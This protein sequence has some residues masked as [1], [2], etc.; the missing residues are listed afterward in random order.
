MMNAHAIPEIHILEE[1]EAE[2]EALYR[3]LIHNDNVTPM[4]FVVH[5]LTTIFFLGTPNAMDIM[6]K[7]HITGTAYVQTVS[8]SEAEKRVNKAHSLA[9]TQGYPLQFSMEPE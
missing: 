8:K 9:D 4:D 7:A 1:T 3:I 2:F 5:V 6:L